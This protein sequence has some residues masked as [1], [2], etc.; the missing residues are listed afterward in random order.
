MTRASQ[1]F[2]IQI[3]LIDNAS[4]DRT[5]KVLQENIGTRYPDVVIFPQAHNLGYT[6]GINLGLQQCA[7]EYVL[8]LNPDVVLTPTCLTELLEQFRSNEYIGAVAPQLRNTDGTIQLSCRRLPHKHDVL[9]RVLGFSAVFRS[10]ALFNGW[11]MPDFDHSKS[12]LVE[13]PQG[14][15]LLVKRAVLESVGRL[16]DQFPMFFSDV[17]W[18][19]RIMRTGWQIRF[20]AEALAYHHQGASVKQRRAEMIVSSHRSFYDYFA[21]YDKKSS[22]R[23]GTLFVGLLLLIVLVPRLIYETLRLT[24]K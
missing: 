18:C 24:R 3:F 5:L 7:G 20:C 19:R 6:K 8:L 9:F 15:F 10:S 12:R 17:D 14:A 22:D 4:Q 1:S 13:Q 23:I 16:D 21:K 2:R 11:Y